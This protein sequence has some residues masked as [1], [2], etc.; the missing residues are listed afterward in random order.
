MFNVGVKPFYSVHRKRYSAIVPGQDETNAIK[1]KD[2]SGAK[3]FTEK[4]EFL[5]VFGHI[6]VMSMQYSI[7]FLFLRPE[8]PPTTKMHVLSLNWEILWSKNK[9]CEILFLAT[10]SGNCCIFSS[11]WPIGIPR[12]VPFLLCVKCKLNRIH[13]HKATELSFSYTLTDISVR[14]K[15]TAATIATGWTKDLLHGLFTYRSGSHNQWIFSTN[16]IIPMCMHFVPK[17]R[18]FRIK[19]SKRNLKFE[20]NC[21]SMT[22]VVNNLM[23]IRLCATTKSNFSFLENHRPHFRAIELKLLFIEMNRHFSVHYCFVVSPLYLCSIF[24]ANMHS[25]CP[26]LSHFTPSLRS[27]TLDAFFLLCAF[28]NCVIKKNFQTQREYRPRNWIKKAFYIHCVTLLLSMLL[29]NWD[30]SF[31]KWKK[32]EWILWPAMT[33]KQNYCRCAY[34]SSLFVGRAHSKDTQSTRMQTQQQEQNSQTS[35]RTK[36]QNWM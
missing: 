33:I 7:C 16:R 21:K 27:E 32:A 18:V 26:F 2:W 25:G 11:V 24:K 23:R 9:L 12:Y 3:Y 35:A 1:K 17:W 8:K 5:M 30:F 15:T 22:V 36:Q 29:G 13:A 19:H 14:T 10:E 31:K 20:I 6:G 4:F 34:Y 28:L